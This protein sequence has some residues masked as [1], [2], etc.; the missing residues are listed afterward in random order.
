MTSSTTRVALI[1][2]GS[3]D[4][5]WCQRLHDFAGHLRGRL[6]DDRA[7]LCFMEISSPTLE[8]VAREAVE[9]GVTR[10][11]I[12]PVFMASGGHVDRDIPRQAREVGELHPGLEVEVLPPL[13]EHEEVVAAMAGVV[14][15]AV[16]ESP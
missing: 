7:V 3:R 16:E 4:P 11:R 8:D 1:A 6:G 9:A 10:L 2:H 12:L 13:G 15:R 5:A 14:E